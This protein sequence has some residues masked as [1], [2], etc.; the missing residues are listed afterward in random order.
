M[1]NVV[2]I[3]KQMPVMVISLILMSF[4]MILTTLLLLYAKQYFSTLMFG[5]RISNVKSESWNKTS[6]EALL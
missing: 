1:L 2:R 3:I 6:W 5:P 4:S